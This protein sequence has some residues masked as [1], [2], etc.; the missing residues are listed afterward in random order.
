LARHYVDSGCDAGL[1]LE[2]KPALSEALD[3]TSTPITTDS[4]QLIAG[5]RG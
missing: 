1:M 2:P 4:P 5:D 3:A